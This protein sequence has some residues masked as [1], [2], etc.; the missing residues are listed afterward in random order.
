MDPVLVASIV[1]VQNALKLGKQ[2]YLFGLLL[3]PQQHLLL[4]ERIAAI[5]QQ[6]KKQL[7]DVA[8]ARTQLDQLGIDHPDVE[9]LL[10]RWAAAIGKPTATGQL[11]PP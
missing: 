9:A 1:A 7:I 6:L 5:E 3:T 11:I 8:S 2:R 4:V 10:A